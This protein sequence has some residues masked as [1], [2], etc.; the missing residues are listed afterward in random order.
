MTNHLPRCGLAALI[1][2]TAALS[3]RAKTSV[4][5]STTQAYIQ[6]VMSVTGA[7]PVIMSQGWVSTPQ[8]TVA[9][10]VGLPSA[11]YSL[12]CIW[13]MEA[14]L[15]SKRESAPKKNRISGDDPSFLCRRLRCMVASF[16]FPHGRAFVLGHRDCR[17][18][19]T[20]W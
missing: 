5:A 8:A 1:F 6:A 15:H 13:T 18:S 3:A 12:V 9:T 20:L 16:P 11:R 2:T 14:A 4:T 7:C 10:R 17:I 19:T